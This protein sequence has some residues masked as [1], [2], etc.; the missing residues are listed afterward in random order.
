MFNDPPSL[1][2]Y[3]GMEYTIT[4]FGERMD[5]VKLRQPYMGISGENAGF[6]DDK[7]TIVVEQ[8]ET[9]GLTLNPCDSYTK[10]KIIVQSSAENKKNYKLFYSNSFSGL[11]K[12]VLA[13]DGIYYNL[14]VAEILSNPVIQ[15]VSISKNGQ[16]ITK[17]IAGTEYSI[18]VRGTGLSNVELLTSPNFLLR[19]VTLSDTVINGLVTFE[20]NQQTLVNKIF[21]RK[22][23][24]YGQPQLYEGVVSI[25]TLTVL[26]RP[27]VF[28]PNNTDWAWGPYYGDRGTFFADVTGDGKADAIAVNNSNVFVRR[29]D[30]T[31]FQPNESWT[32]NPYYG[33]RGTFFRDVTGDGRADAIVINN[34][35]IV[36]RRSNGNRF[37][38]NESWTSNPYYG[39]RGTFFADVTGDGKADAIVVNNANI[40][41]RPSIGNSF[42]EQQIWT[43]GAFY[44]ER[45]T[46]F[47]DVDGDG[48]ADVIAVNNNG[49][50]IKKSVG[51]RFGPNETFTANAYYGTRGTFF[52]DVTGDRKA[53]A[54]VINDDKITV[55]RSTGTAF[56]PNEDGTNQAF[57]AQRVNAFAD[58]Y[59]DGKAAVIVVNDATVFVRR[60]N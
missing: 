55:R 60:A 41:V 15:G 4:V 47:A 25:Q 23:P 7:S 50:V 18:R 21:Y 53:D 8:L 13:P 56:S 22:T 54:I 30:G 1:K 49:I 24:F 6:V 10:G 59:G 34:S 12:E 31:A 26:P 44:G 16:P 14:T 42:G 46:D 20:Y 29:S 48:K 2:L 35:N 27:T 5:L 19:N 32:T 58:V 52:V 43:T 28:N 17:P 40:V 39:E 36:V 9:K 3:K 37:T 33:E 38:D 45:G 57:Y 11:A 51:N